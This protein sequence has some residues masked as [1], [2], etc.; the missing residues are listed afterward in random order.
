MKLATLTSTTVSQKATEEVER[1]I[2]EYSTAAGPNRPQVGYEDHFTDA[3]RS[4]VVG[5]L[6]KDKQFETNKEVSGV[7]NHRIKLVSE[8]ICQKNNRA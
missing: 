7:N 6:R 2:G 4:L 8:R 1:H 3:K 5:A